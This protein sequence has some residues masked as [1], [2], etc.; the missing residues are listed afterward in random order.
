MRNLKEAELISVDTRGSTDDIG[1]A[2]AIGLFDSGVGGLTV[3]R[4]LLELLPNEEYIYLGDTARLPYGTKSSDTITRY[5]LQASQ[6]LVQRDIKLLVVAC[7]TATSVALPALR[8]AYPHIPVIGVVEPGAEAACL[9]TKNNS[10][11]V[12][13]TASTVRGG[14]YMRAIHAIEPTT[15]V[16]SVACPLFV[17]LAED[18]LTEGYLAEGIA[19]R[20]LQDCFTIESS[21]KKPDTLVLGCTHFPLLAQAIQNVVG[22]DVTLV[23]SAKTTAHAV[24][25]T[26]NEL[27]IDYTH[28]NPRVR[29]LTTDDREQF[30]KVGRAF[31]GKDTSFDIF[32]ENVELVDL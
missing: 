25:K 16:I 20:Y 9:A 13:G 7:N 32:D 6:A 17:P 31:L 8:E 12:I 28:K 23:D 11:A 26:L 30:I 21:H 15:D 3:L 19:Q 1:R 5:A 2:S 4:A 29:F 27:N 18:G 10:I 22:A 14:A 24:Q